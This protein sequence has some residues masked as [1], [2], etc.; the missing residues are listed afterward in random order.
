[1]P[2]P[3][4]GEEGA[5]TAA[6]AGLGAIALFVLGAA[7]TGGRPAFDAPA[8]ELAAYVA[9]HETEIRVG[10]AA[11]VLAVPSL[12]WFLATPLA[13][14]RDGSAQARRLALVAFACGLGFLT[15]FLADVTTMAVAALRPEAL[16]A[17]PDRAVLLRDLELLLMGSAAPLVS[18]MLACFAALT[19]RGWGPWPRAIGWLA[20]AAGAA[21]ALRF[22]TLLTSEG[23]F[24]ADGALGLYVPVGALLA[25]LLAAAAALG[26]RSRS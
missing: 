6:A 7:L 25:W 2:A 18:T 24:A 17:H 14:L 20:L 4:A 8:S 22:G 10:V 23:P 5:R 13:S 3:S 19:L 15:L 12:L 21:Y 16:A 26:V 11:F 9:E 1:M